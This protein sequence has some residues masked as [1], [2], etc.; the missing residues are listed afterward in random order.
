MDDL[1][2]NFRAVRMDQFS[3]RILTLPNLLTFMRIALLPFLILALNVREESGNVPAIVIG[4]IMIATDLLDG[5]LAR[6]LNQRSKLGWILDPV[7]DKIIV[8]VLAIFFAIRGELPYWVM[9]VVL[10]RDL[11]ILS[12]A[13]PMVK[14]KLF[15]KPV[16]WGRLSPFLW[17]I[18]FIL[19]VANMSYFAWVFIVLA[20]I[21]SIFSAGIY[22]GNYKRV[23]EM[24]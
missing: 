8:D 17:G 21:L 15:P 19:I 23:M 13:L 11:A 16:I 1:G 5:W 4:S 18:A 22:Y 6:I 7:S 14:K 12:F 9:V 2:N 24:E 10:L 20:L 3:D